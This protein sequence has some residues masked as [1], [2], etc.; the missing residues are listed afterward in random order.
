[1]LSSSRV[2]I[3]AGRW[4]LESNK[5][6][7]FVPPSLNDTAGS[8]CLPR[9][10]LPAVATLFGASIALT[11]NHGEA[12]P[13][14]AQMRRDTDAGHRPAALLVGDITERGQHGLREFQLHRGVRV[15]LVAVPI[16]ARRS[17]R[18]IPSHR[19]RRVAEET[20]LSVGLLRLL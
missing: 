5:I 10:W 9:F 18:K 14:L 4:V 15:F 11:S 7:N 20:R 8:D 3:A 1:M 16:G 2:R 13:E 17:V 12:R 6:V 19:E